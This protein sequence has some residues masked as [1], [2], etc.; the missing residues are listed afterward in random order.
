MIAR[1]NDWL[2][3]NESPSF[4]NHRGLNE[5]DY[6][7]NTVENYW[8]FGICPW[9]GNWVCDGGHIALLGSLGRANFNNWITHV[10]FSTAI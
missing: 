1:R 5:E 2:R 3:E 7:E 6:N 10:R 8:V 9:S 4:L